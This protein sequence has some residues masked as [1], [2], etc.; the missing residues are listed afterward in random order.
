MKK[1]AVIIAV[2]LAL[3]TLA[4]CQGY[5]LGELARENKLALFNRARL[6]V[7]SGLD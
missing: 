7:G 2:F 4:V 3:P 6:K 1:T 5:N